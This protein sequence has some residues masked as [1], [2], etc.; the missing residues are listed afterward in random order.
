M[1]DYREGHQMAE[2]KLQRS[3]IKLEG[4]LAMAVITPEDDRRYVRLNIGPGY[5]VNEQRLV[6][7]P[8]V[9][10]DAH[11]LGQAL[12]EHALECGYDPD[13]GDTR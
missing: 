6:N 5:G 11:A 7:Y 2:G 3:E 9:P 12:T 1:Q 8:L 13:T 4:T 10:E